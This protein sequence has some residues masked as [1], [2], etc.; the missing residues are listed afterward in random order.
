M[1]KILLSIAVLSFSLAQCVTKTNP[2]AE[3]AAPVVIYDTIKIEV[4]APCPPCEDFS[5]VMDSI[6]FVN[7]RLADSLLHKKL[8]I[9]NVQYYL[10]IC[11]KNPS[12]DKFLK[13][14]IKRAVQ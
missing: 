13:G 5:L 8:I 1:S 10:N 14:W 7:R 12:Q 9:S 6:A 2:T 3:N 4:A 11:L